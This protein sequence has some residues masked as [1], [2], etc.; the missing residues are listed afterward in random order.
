MMPLNR[1][2]YSSFSNKICAQ[3]RIWNPLCIP[4]NYYGWSKVRYK[5]YNFFETFLVGPESIYHNEIVRS[6][7]QI[8]NNLNA[9]LAI[10]INIC[11]ENKCDAQRHDRLLRSFAN[12]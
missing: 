3:K 5:D 7:S 11:E 12:I 6:W 8:A 10:K 1:N 4:Q 9:L 2:N